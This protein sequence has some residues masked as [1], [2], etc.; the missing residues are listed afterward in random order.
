MQSSN[1]PD[2]KLSETILWLQNKTPNEKELVPVLNELLAGGSFLANVLQGGLV[3]GS[4]IL[5]RFHIFR[6]A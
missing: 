5:V 3:V 1:N 4:A 2:L 6:L